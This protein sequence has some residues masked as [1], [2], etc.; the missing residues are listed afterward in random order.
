MN[1]IIRK[2]KENIGSFS[3][4]VPTIVLSVAKKLPTDIGFIL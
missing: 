2:K 3:K 4:W 1:E